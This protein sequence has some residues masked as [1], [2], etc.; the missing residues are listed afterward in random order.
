MNPVELPKTLPEA[1]AVILTLV[2]E[3]NRLREEFESRLEKQEAIIRKQQQRIEELERRLGQNSQN[4]SQPPSIDPP[5]APRRPR[6]ASTGRKPGGQP[7]HEGHQRTLLPPERVNRIEPLWPDRCDNCR[8]QLP[9]GPKRI[10]VGAPQRHQVVELPVLVANVTE[11]QL[12]AQS[13]PCCGHT[14]V[15]KL[16][17]GVPTSSFGP[18]LQ[19]IV[20][21]LSSV[22]RLSKRAL[23][24]LLAEIFSV[25]MSLGAIIACEHRTS[26][27]VA[28][29]VAEAAEY[30][31]NEAILN[32][33]E[34]GWRERLRRAWLWVA[35]TASVT[36]F[37]IHA[38][39]GAAAAGKLLG[40]F[41]GILGSDR[42][43]A[44]A[45]HR[46]RKR[47][48]CWAHLRRH[49]VAFA[50]YGKRTE[51]RR[52]GARLLAATDKMFEWW[53]RIRDGTMSR[54][55]FQRKMKPIRKEVEQLL[56]RGAVC[57]QRKVKA[58]CADLLKLAPAM[59]TFV[60]VPGVEP[61]N[62]AA[63]RALRH[64][65]VLRK[66]SFGTHSED[67]SRFLERMLTV[68][69]TLKQQKRNVL[70]YLVEACERDLLGERP[71]SLLPH[72]RIIKRRPPSIDP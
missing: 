59:W 46:L 33:D 8:Q 41:A 64:A 12:H 72:A 13:C 18:R 70:D 19:A 4:S 68:A 31:Q 57:R 69:A 43:C 34:T 2:G 32:A 23:R 62:N 38:K 42:W 22:Y 71:R 45:G 66:T 39:R 37:L 53:H 48:L 28:E 50:E 61:T 51:A 35:V 63:E 5:S 60:R 65:V 40:R 6:K 16:P 30:V 49:F 58:T 17:A 36:V 24:S 9:S 20:S 21:A 52:I 26:A 55:T 44:Y 47:Q 25:E 67:G 54:A 3:I 15:A 14:T 10:E 7:G 11:Y 29:P 27:A 56:R 1:H